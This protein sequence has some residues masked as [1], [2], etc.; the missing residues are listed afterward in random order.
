M[1][2]IDFDSRQRWGGL[3][4]VA[5]GVTQVMDA[6]KV[7]WVSKAGSYVVQ[8]IISS[9]SGLRKLNVPQK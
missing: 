9:D 7:R 3:G 5:A 1:K 4:E 2:S 8:R 6:T